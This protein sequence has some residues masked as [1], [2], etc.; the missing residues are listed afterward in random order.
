MGRPPLPRPCIVCGTISNGPRCKAHTTKRHT[1]ATYNGA[2]RQL[3]RAINNTG[4][5]TCRGCLEYKRAEDIQIDHTTPLASGGQD[6]P[7]NVQ[8]LCRDCHAAKTAAEN[9]QRNATG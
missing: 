9:Q 3:R 1:R 4:G 5:A 6:S 8:P 2:G 7:A